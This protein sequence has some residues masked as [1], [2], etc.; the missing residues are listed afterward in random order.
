MAD[1]AVRIEG[2]AALRRDLRKMQPDALAEVRDA[3]RSGAAVVAVR[4]RANAPRGTR[5]IPASRRPRKRLADTIAPGTAGNSAFVRS[6]AVYGPKIDRQTGFLTRALE[7][8]ADQVADTVGD[9][10]DA[11]AARNGWH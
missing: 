8:T 11:L 6:R 7:D 1:D 2:L 5:E 4:G 9:A 3:L 10:I